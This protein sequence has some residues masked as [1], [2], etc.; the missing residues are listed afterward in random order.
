M[1]RARGLIG[2]NEEIATIGELLGKPL[3][4]VVRG[5]PGA[6]KTA[7]L[8]GVASGCRDRNIRTITVE[9]TSAE[10]W[11]LF[12]AQAILRALRAG[13]TDIGSSR[14]ATALDTVNQL[15]TQATYA[16]PA[17]RGRL[18]H[19]LQRLFDSFHGSTPA[20]VLF[21][22]VDADPATVITATS[23]ALRAGCTVVVACDDETVALELTSARDAAG[24]IVE[25]GPLRHEDLGDLVATVT[26]HQ[27]DPGVAR[28]IRAA[29]GSLAGNPGAVLAVC[30]E[31]TRQGRLT[32]L[33]GALCLA[34]PD[35]PIMLPADHWLVRTVERTHEFGPRLLAL[36]ADSEW[37]T[38]D[39][40]ATFAAA[41][42][43]ELG[44]CGRAID[45]FTGIGALRCAPNGVLT[46]A[47]PALGAAAID[48][49]GP[50]AL[51]ALHLSFARHLGPAS[52]D[53]GHVLFPLA[54]HLAAAGALAVG[55]PDAARVLDR[56]ARRIQPVNSTLAAHW[57]RAALAHHDPADRP[58]LRAELVRELVR[59]GRYDWLGE[60]TEDGE[61]AAAA[62]LAALHTGTPPPEGVRVP[63]VERWFGADDTFTAADLAEALAPLGGRPPTFP[64]PE[65]WFD[66][67]GLVESVL[68]SAYGTPRRGPLAVYRRIVED[69][70]RGQWDDALSGARTLVATYPATTPVHELARLLA[71]E[72]CGRRGEP[73][74]A[75]GWLGASDA[76]PTVRGWVELGL[77]TDA[78][79]EFGWEADQHPAG[80]HLLIIRHAL[81]ATTRGDGTGL[82]EI[83]E[84]AQAWCA[85]RDE[86]DPMVIAVARNSYAAARAAASALRE[87]GYQAELATACLIAA[88]LADDPR[89]W[90]CAADDIAEQLGDTWLRI[91]I[92]S[93]T[94]T[95]G[96]T[97]PRR[98][99]GSRTSA[100]VEARII[101]LIQQGMTNRQ[102]AA[103]IQVSEKSVERHLTKL[104]AKAGCR[105]RLGLVAAYERGALS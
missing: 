40:L 43:G 55:E 32:P 47:C 96:V 58:R 19:Q 78:T 90:L 23:I 31:L 26:R 80:L 15:C 104:F 25:L 95:R 48:A 52:R 24:Q 11:D 46:V 41:I 8:D 102:I 6:G 75:E 69:Y 35:A 37:F 45:E 86:P 30:E 101:E 28:A 63:I 33:G 34:D 61:F 44:A 42:D 74:L 56:A 39:D 1:S 94:R 100:K 13:F 65:G 91:H 27:S 98:T 87:Q 83:Q 38:M 10:G 79:L 49:V 12:G 16:S 68:G 67:I 93:L 62:G 36:I 81:L 97:L 17:S 70:R 92:K 5:G 89:P 88:R 103:A 84:A 60:V 18:L 105:S 2:R 66:P 99:S 76:F 4:I 64:R 73:D 9:L 54:D 59:I 14:L 71:A 53:L 77:S 22:D 72:M 29:L 7:L 3:P 51:R 82:A 50:A 21:D 57:Q 85:E 20:V